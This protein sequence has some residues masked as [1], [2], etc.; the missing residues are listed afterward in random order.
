[1]LSLPLTRSPDISSEDVNV[2]EVEF[3]EELPLSETF[4]ETT[5]VEE[6]ATT[7]LIA[8]PFRLKG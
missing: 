7:S 2:G 3:E 8:L 1:M 5:G 4:E 6:E